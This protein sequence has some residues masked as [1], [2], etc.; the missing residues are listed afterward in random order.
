M[1]TNSHCAMTTAFERDGGAWQKS[2]SQLSHHQTCLLGPQASS[3]SLI[4]LYS[5]LHLVLLLKVS[6]NILYCHFFH[7]IAA[8]SV[9]WVGDWTWRDLTWNYC[10]RTHKCV[11]VLFL[12][13]D[14]CSCQ[15]Y[16]Y[17]F[18]SVMFMNLVWAHNR[19]Q[20]TYALILISWLHLLRA[21]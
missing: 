15:A 10:V 8:T 12:H 21:R 18:M 3:S 2:W 20:Y 11:T 14:C 4:L 1:V 19:Q 17:S 13:F 5:L 7:Q 9:E 6:N 16:C